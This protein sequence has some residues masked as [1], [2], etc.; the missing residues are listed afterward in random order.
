MSGLHEEPRTTLED[1]G[2]IP[3]KLSADSVFDTTEQ[4]L[5]KAAEVVGNGAP[6][7]A[8]EEASG[9]TS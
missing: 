6:Q 9:A 2:A 4:A 7:Q 3:N 8:S 5:A 1:L